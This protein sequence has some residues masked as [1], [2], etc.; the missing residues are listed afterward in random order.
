MVLKELTP[1]IAA[2]LA[3][4]EVKGVVAEEG[5]GILLMRQ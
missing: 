5:L 1:I 2:S 4:K 3:K